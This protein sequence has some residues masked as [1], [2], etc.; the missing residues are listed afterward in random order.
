MKQQIRFCTSS[1]GV[2]IA[3]ATSGDGPPLVRVAHWLTHL[4]YDWESPIWSH[5]FEELS[6]GHRLVRYDSRGSGLSDRVVDDISLESWVQDLEMVVD[7]LGLDQ[8]PLLGFCQGGATAVAYAVRYPERVSRL[9]LYDGY[10]HG[11]FADGAATHEKRQAEALAE[12]I[13]V[14]WGRQTAAFRQVFADL[15]IP[16]AGKEQQRWL[17]ELQRRTVSAQTAGRLWRAFNSIDIRDLAPQVK[18]PTLVLHVRDDSMVPFEYGRQ[19]A[20]LIPD[21]R[22]V[23]LEGRN[24]ILM[25]DD[26]AW[27]RFLA[28]VRGF[29]G[30]RLSERLPADLE[31]A[32]STLTPREREVLGLVAQGLDN[33]EIAGRLSIAPKTVRNHV[34][35]IYGK[36]CVD[37]RAQAVVLAREAILEQ[38]TG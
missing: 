26:T 5:W 37:N 3:Y 12:M 4:D 25:E 24:H 27:P 10:A 31:K 7:D 36:L 19:L 20:S 38:E 15:L 11:P 23:P 8:F 33:T 6:R 13:D 29:L 1:D 16:G 2:R 14:G 34:S 22:F 18:V 21:A 35:R 32:V 17:A 9:V 30:T 28:E